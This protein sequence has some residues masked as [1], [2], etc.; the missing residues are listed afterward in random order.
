YQPYRSPA[1]HANDGTEIPTRG[2]LLVRRP[3]GARAGSAGA[4]NQPLARE[5]CS[6][7]SRDTQSAAPVV[8]RAVGARAITADVGLHSFDTRGSDPAAAGRPDPQHDRGRLAR[9]PDSLRGPQADA[10]RSR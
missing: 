2:W 9:Q 7:P 3:G 4:G 6:R 10:G 5:A 8:D 1:T